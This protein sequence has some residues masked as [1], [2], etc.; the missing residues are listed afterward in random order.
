MYL[1]A[2]SGQMLIEDLVNGFYVIFPV[3][4]FQLPTKLFQIKKLKA[5]HKSYK[6]YPAWRGIVY[7]MAS[8]ILM[9]LTQYHITNLEIAI[10]KKQAKIRSLIE[11]VLF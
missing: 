2:V 10:Q 5:N 8:S 1:Y 4:K 9:S 11:K 7:L 6:I 3:Q